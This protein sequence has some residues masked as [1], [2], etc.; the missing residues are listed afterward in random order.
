MVSHVGSADPEND[1]FG[2]VRGVIRHAFE[3]ARDQQG[4]QRLVRDLQ[5]DIEI[6]GLPIV[7]EPDGLAMSSRNAYLS[8]EERQAAT[9]L[10]RALRCA[11][12]LFAAGDRD[13]ER[14]RGS[15]R[16]LIAAEQLARVDYVS[17]ADAET[18]GELD[19]IEEPALASL[20]VRIGAVRLIDNVTLEA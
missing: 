8:H 17:V 7:R 1:V 2:D 6:V 16:E 4:V 10:S 12:E 18:L 9:V 13:A 11:E 3:V 15:M 14:L 5:L 20:A 19:R